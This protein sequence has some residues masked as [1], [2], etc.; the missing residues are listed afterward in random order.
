MST[1]NINHIISR[2]S[3]DEKQLAKELFPNN[4]HP[5]VAF[6]RVT[7]G[8]SFLDT[9]QVTTLASILGVHVS[10]LYIDDN[11]VMDKN[12][13]DNIVVFF[14]NNY[15]V[16]LDLETLVSSIYSIDKLI[17]KETLISEKNI[18]LSEYLKSLNET[19]IN[20]I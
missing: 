17:A 13:K 4:L 10:D 7:S 18:K 9:N 15:R 16:E 2:Y 6:K 12:V 1:F 11:W 19:I 20:L 14:K 3:I 5:N 8:E